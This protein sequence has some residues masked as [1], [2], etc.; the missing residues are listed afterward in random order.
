MKVYEIT[1]HNFREEVLASQRP[2]LLTF[3]APWCGAC[4]QLSPVLDEIAAECPDIKV[5][6]VNADT[7]PELASRYNISRIPTLLIMSCAEEEDRVI[8]APEKEEILSLF[9]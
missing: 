5:C 4:K 7:E 2:V 8:G 9:E 6:S 3:R 1:R